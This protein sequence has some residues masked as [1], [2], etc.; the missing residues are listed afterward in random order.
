M[1]E[2]INISILVILFAGFLYEA[3]LPIIG[4]IPKK[5]GKH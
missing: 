3:Y 5:I 1:T 2:F 4:E